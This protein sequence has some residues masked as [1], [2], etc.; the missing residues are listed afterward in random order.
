MFTFPVGFFNLI[1]SGG[2][3][4]TTDPFAA[5][6]VLFLKADQSNL[7]TNTTTTANFTVPAVNST[8]T[9]NVVSSGFAVADRAIRIGNSAGNYIITAVPSGT[10]LTIRNCGGSDNAAVSSV[11]SSGVTIA[12]SI[13]DSSPSPKNISAFG[14][15]QI[16]TTQSKYGGS[17]LFFNGTSDHLTVTH[18]TDFNFASGDFTWE[19]WVYPTAI[20][21]CLAL[22]GNTSPN[23]FLF[24]GALY[25]R[26]QVGGGD[27]MV[28]AQN[29]TLN[30]QQHFAITRQET[31]YRYFI[32][33]TLLY[34]N[35]T[36]TAIPANT[37]LIIG[38]QSTNTALSLQFWQGYVD[39]LRVTRACRYTS[40]FNPETDTYLNI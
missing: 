3:G 4:G 12:L 37:T 15:A 16:S 31:T 32:N 14:N 30:T 39:S 22:S 26:T 8:V 29:V 34:T 1:V 17:S 25:L 11:I 24:G 10:Q 5:N 23:L 40:N 6:V 2:G 13:I 20:K 18:P 36:A 33:G 7:V 19:A 28:T 21:E 9:I 38:S 27:L 35:T